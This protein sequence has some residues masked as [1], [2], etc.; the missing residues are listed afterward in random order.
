MFFHAHLLNSDIKNVPANPALQSTR[1]IISTV[2][3]LKNNF[4]SPLVKVRAI[5]TIIAYIFYREKTSFSP[6]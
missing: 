3:D 6:S 2:Q 5:G 4:I 1:Q